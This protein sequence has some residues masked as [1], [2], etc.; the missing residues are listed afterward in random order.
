MF[1]IKELYSAMESPIF[2][3]SELIAAINQSLEDDYPSVV[4]EGDEA[5]FKVNRSKYVFFD[6]KDDEGVVGCFMMVYQLRL[7]LEDGMRVRLI[8]QPRL[9]SWGKFSLTVR[10][11]MPIGEGSIKRSFELLKQNLDKEG[12]F[13][14]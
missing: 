12:L 8:A 13:D 3:V 2:Q 9:T 14:V 7:A 6:L 11:V 5:S 1:C 10:E 4:V